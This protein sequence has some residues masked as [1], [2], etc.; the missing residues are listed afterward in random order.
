M[1]IR[2]QKIHSKIIKSSAV[3]Q[4]INEFSEQ[5]VT[6]FSRKRSSDVKDRASSRT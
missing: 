1:V 2:F 6:L 5:I 3:L 4:K